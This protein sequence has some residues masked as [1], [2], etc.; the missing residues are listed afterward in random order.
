MRYA[1]RRLS[2]NR[3]VRTGLGTRMH[4]LIVHKIICKA[5]VIYSFFS[6]EHFGS[7]IKFKSLFRDFYTPT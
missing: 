5:I 3:S 7:E 2:Q 6:F 1:S 4:F